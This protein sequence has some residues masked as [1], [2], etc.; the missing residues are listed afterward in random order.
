MPGRRSRL[1][2]AH[3]VAVHVFLQG[4]NL[5]VLDFQEKCVAVGIFLAVL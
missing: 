2:R 1:K 3:V 4:K 5:V